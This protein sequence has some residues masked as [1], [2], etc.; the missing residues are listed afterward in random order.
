M[1]IVVVLTY[2]ADPRVLVGAVRAAA[3]AGGHDGVVVVDNS[4][5][6]H[7]ADAVDGER[8]S[9]V[10]T[11]R[12]LNNRGFGGGVNLGIRHALN[13]GATEVAVLNDDVDVSPG[14]LE[15]LAAVLRSKPR[16][17]AVQPKLLLAGAPRPTVNSVGVAG[18]PDGAWAD[19][20]FGAPD[21]PAFTGLR[22]VPAVTGG[23]ALF[24]CDALRDVGLFD[25]QLFM[26]YE[27]VDLCLRLRGAGWSCWCEPASEVHHQVGGSD[28]TSPRMAYYRERNR[29]VL[30]ARHAD[31]RTAA[32]GVWLGLRR[33]RHHPRRA[34]LRAL[35]G[36]L[37]RWPVELVRRRGR[38]RHYPATSQRG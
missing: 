28:G 34:H 2:N 12:A 36:A 1:V 35:L 11:M 37:A 4:S 32:R 7:L 5:D 31:A 19:I 29:L 20:G 13:I 17:A 6:G 25:E 16:A 9:G 10:T 26:Y 3:D 8:C 33:V 18:G 24:R 23:A 38:R 21:G 15:P 30:L 27:D 22:E 14:W